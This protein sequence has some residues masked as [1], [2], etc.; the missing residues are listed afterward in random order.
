VTS[1]DLVFLA[2]AGAPVDA[3]ALKERAAG[4][5]E[6]A[7]GFV[8]ETGDALAQLRARVA[9]QAEPASAFALAIAALQA[10]DGS[11]APFEAPSRGWVGRELEALG[12]HPRLRG[13]LEALAL[14]SDARQDDA[15][16]AEA[17]VRFVEAAQ[18][19]DGCFASFAG[20]PGDESAIVVLT[21]IAAGSVG[22][23]RY[24]RPE[25]LADAGA[26][27]GQRF[28]PERVEAGHLAER[29][30]FAMYYSNAPDELSDEALQWCGRELERGFRSHALEALEVMQTLL[31]CQ[32]GSLPGASFAPEELLERLLGEQAGDG[33]FDAL[34]PGGPLL[35]VAPTIDAMRAVIGLCA[36]F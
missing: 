36:T 19:L 33:G 7:L 4:A 16:C 26:W 21:G 24:A 6:R 17:A 14:L 22:R 35:R 5:L 20:A 12:V 8:C 2:A 9:L 18:Q 30:A 32:A 29:T 13:T 15:P 10:D 11:F 31:A 3:T 28:A 25:A 34:S 1:D 27:L 23:S